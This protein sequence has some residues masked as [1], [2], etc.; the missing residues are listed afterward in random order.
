VASTAIT[1]F[2]RPD[3]EL[4][5]MLGVS[6]ARLQFHSMEALAAFA[7]PT[8]APLP[9][10]V[11]VDLRD[12]T[13]L[14]A[15]VAQLRRQHPNVGVVIIASTLDPSLM[16]EAMRAGVHEFVAEPLSAAALVA[17]VQR[18]VERPAPKTSDGQVFAFVGA[19][20]G[21]GTTTVAVNVATALAKVA[22]GKSLLVDLHLAHGDAALLL[23]AEP[24]FT[25]SDALENIHRMDEAY[26]GALVTATKNG[27][28]LLASAERP[29]PPAR[30]PAKVRELIGFGAQ[31]Y[32]YV[33]LDVPRSDMTMLDSLEQAS[34]IL[35]IAN[36]ELATVRRAGALALTL[37]QRYGKDRV[38]VVMNRFDRSAEIGR[39]DVERVI[40]G[41]VRHVIPSDY[42]IALD[43][44]N[45]GQPVVVENHNRLAGSFTSLARLLAGLESAASIADERRPTG[46][47]GRLGMSRS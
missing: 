20:G 12:E 36:Q 40:G 28:H 24:R 11:I 19:K 2:G 22:R 10:G 29:V 16:L 30:E 13:R 1:V 42:R 18:V 33:V 31:H 6:G 34:S 39:E 15:T 4:G 43:G 3:P 41:S 25:T 26:L 17:A 23:G 14:P 21:V 5:E 9:D 46:L 8:Q 44:L 7:A 27:V 32:P 47:F 37:R 35:V 45:K 38:G